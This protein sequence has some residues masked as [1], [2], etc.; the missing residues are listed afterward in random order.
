MS[1]F[2]NKPSKHKHLTEVTTLD[3]IHKNYL[4]NFQNNKKSVPDKKKKIKIL[5]KKLKDYNLDLSVKSKILSEIDDLK[6]EIKV[7]ENDSQILEYVSKGGDYILN[8]YNLTSGIYYNS[9]GITNEYYDS[10]IIQNEPNELEN[11]EKKQDKLKE[12][13]NISK[14]TRKVKKPVKKRIIIHDVVKSKSILDF[15]PI[16]ND[17]L[18]ASRELQES[19]KSQK[20]QESQEL[21]ESQESQTIGSDVIL[22]RATLQHKFLMIVDSSYACGKV[23]THKIIFCDKCNKEKI[24]IP[25][26]GNYTCELCGDTENSMMENELSNHKELSN[27]KQKYPYKKINHFKEKLNQFQSKESSD[28]PQDV[29]NIILQDLKKRKMSRYK[30]TPIIIRKILKKHKLTNWY[31]HLQQVYCKISETQPI[32]LSS[33]IEETIINMFLAMQELFRKYR[34][35]TRSNFLSYSYVLNKIFRILKMPNHAKY[36]GLL[37]S[38][39]KLREHDII[40]AKICADLGWDFYSSSK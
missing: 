14:L 8:Y 29:C 40:W 9:E 38:K 35:S 39:P 25:S 12:L 2:K 32:T 30:C 6:N 20:S 1:S 26:E 24:L 3:E 23:K 21:R 10:C 11:N 36:F 22:N 7:A 5:K 16:K 27:E 19:Q 18:Q 34:S 28:I 37:K 31:E 13:N 17:K 33:D 4:L 15:L